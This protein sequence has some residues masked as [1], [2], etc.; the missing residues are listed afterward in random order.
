MAKAL[1]R[2]IRAQ[3]FGI[4]ANRLTWNYVQ[5]SAHHNGH[6]GEPSWPFTMQL[7]YMCRA[8]GKRVSPPFQ[9]SRALSGRDCDRAHGRDHGPPRDFRGLSDPRAT[10]SPFGS[11]RSG[12][13]S[14]WP[15]HRV[16]GPSVLTPICSENR[17]APNSH[18][19][20][21]SPVP[22]LGRA[23]RNAWRADRFGCTQTPALPQTG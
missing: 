9:W 7:A 17:S 10:S 21:H 16:D 2:A 4:A 8:I 5:R 11:G 13:G 1:G 12:G 14:T 20:R 23:V 19:P 18:R 15:P 3:F 6:T 22:A